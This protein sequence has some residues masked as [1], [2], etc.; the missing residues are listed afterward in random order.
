MF[1]R[2][3]FNFPHVFLLSRLR[4]YGFGGDKTAIY[5]LLLSDSI[6]GT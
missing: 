2:M 6:Q 3:T 4:H 1:F 5:P